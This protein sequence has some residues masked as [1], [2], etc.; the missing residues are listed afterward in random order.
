MP[1]YHPQSKGNKVTDEEFVKAWKACNGNIVQVAETTGMRVRGVLGRRRS[2]EGR[3]GISLNAER[4][5]VA[6][7]IRK[8]K[9][10]INLTVKDAVLPIG[11]DVHVAPG[12][13][14]T[15]QQAY[16]NI[17][18][19]LRPRHVILLGDV[20]DGAR[21]SRHPRI[22]FLEDRPK[23]VDEI[24]AVGEF[25]TALEEAAPKEAM[26]IWCLGNHDARYESYLASS[27]PEMEGVQGMHLKDHFPKWLPCWAV[28]INEGTPGY[29]VLKHR[30][31][32]GIHATYNNTLKG[33]V[34]IV[35]GHL[36]KLD[37]RKWRDFTGRRYGVDAGFMADIDDPQFVHYTE[38]NAKDWDS[39][40]PVLTYKDGKLMRPEFVQ[41]WDEH[42]VEFRG[43]LVAA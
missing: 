2:V 7:V 23:V 21:I 33:G 19:K 1:G 25:L 24:K 9:A 8:H 4:D 42:H 28:H 16:I 5:N 11:G 10:R 14:T 40:F 32:N 26:L 15:V 22:G 36:H 34:N 30:W 3:M 41:K 31:H 6:A 39:G 37:A 35:T 13:R 29:T 17:V 38:D 20:F 27:A 12:P 18:K 43:E